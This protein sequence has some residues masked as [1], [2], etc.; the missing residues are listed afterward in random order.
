MLLN[1]EVIDN[2]PSLV[3]KHSAPKHAFTM[4]VCNKSDDTRVGVEQFIQKG[5]NQ[6]YDANVQ[7]NTPYLIS[8]TQGQLKAALGLRSAREQLFSQQYLSL[9]IVELLA[10]LKLVIRPSEIAEIGHLFSNAKMFT[11]PLMLVT[12][13]ALQMH[14]FK[15]MVFTGTEHVIKL[16]KKTGVVTH[17]LASADQTKLI[18]STNDWG[19]YYASNP[20]VVAI[21]L[22]QVIKVVET[23]P[24][25]AAMFSVLRPQIAKVAKQL[26]GI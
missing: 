23:S 26:E 13:I 5:F 20:Q 24:K 18:S 14:G 15:F 16:I 10:P 19:S 4:M 11:I 8:L 2:K 25:F 1:S 7:I 12:A 6:K 22:A 3:G 9:P 17:F 21:D